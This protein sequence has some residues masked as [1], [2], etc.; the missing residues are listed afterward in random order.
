MFVRIGVVIGASLSLAVG[1]EAGTQTAPFAGHR[2]THDTNTHRNVIGDIDEDGH[3]DL[4]TLTDGTHLM[5]G[6]LTA[7]S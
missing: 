4:L 7:R 2:L 1:G 6:Q 3:R 5:L